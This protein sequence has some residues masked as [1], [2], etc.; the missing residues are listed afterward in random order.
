MPS[1]S[2]P[3]SGIQPITMA[4]TKKAMPTHRKP[5]TTETRLAMQIAKL[6]F[7]ASNGATLS[8]ITR[9]TAK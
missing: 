9:G 7:I 5:T 1:A 2:A 8:S 6:S 4:T 3:S